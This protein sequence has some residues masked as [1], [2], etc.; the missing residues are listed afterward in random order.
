M[1]AIHTPH[2]F[3]KPFSGLNAGKDSEDSVDGSVFCAGCRLVFMSVNSVMILFNFS[4]LVSSLLLITASKDS[5]AFQKSATFLLRFFVVLSIFFCGSFSTF[6]R[7]RF[8]P[9]P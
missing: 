8:M 7:F 9:S 1:Q 4:T 3:Q 6:D 5:S 2:H